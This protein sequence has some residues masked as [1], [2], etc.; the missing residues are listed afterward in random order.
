MKKVAVVFG[1]Y[2]TQYVGMGKGLYDNYR[3]IQEFFEEAYSCQNMN[4]VK[5]CF[6]A[7]DVDLAEINASYQSIFLY[8]S[9][10]FAML[11]ESGLE[12]CAVTGL[13]LGYY[14]AVYTA[15]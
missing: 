14:P 1:G 8:S 13:D 4:F 10:L 5:L 7:S 11:K 12:V 15:G 3:L 9:A 2:G 6:A